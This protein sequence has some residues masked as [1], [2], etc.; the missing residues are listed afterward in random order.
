[1]SLK[2]KLVMKKWI[3]LFVLLHVVVVVVAQSQKSYTFVIQPKSNSQVKGSV[4]IKE[5]KN[6]T[7]V[8]HIQAENITPGKHGVHLHAIGDCSSEDGMS[9]GGHWNPYR[10]EH[11]FCK[12]GN[13]NNVHA[14]DMG[15]LEANTDGHVNFTFTTADWCINCQDSNKNINYKALIIHE[16]N[17][18][19]SS[20]P[21]GNSGK[22]IG[23][24]VLNFN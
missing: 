4:L 1:M 13:C 16:K 8:L 2:F 22:R 11:G 20:Q 18:D 19:L 15:N 6:K 12:K 5:N 10:K 14:G 23:C 3:T 21:T 24:V 7:V 9:A 17:D